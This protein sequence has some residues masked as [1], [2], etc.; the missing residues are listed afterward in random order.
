[1]KHLFLT[2]AAVVVV[3]A[4]CTSKELV[5]EHSDAM[6]AAIAAYVEEAAATNL[7]INSIM[8]LHHGKVVGEAYVN[9]WT[10]DSTHHMWSVSKS[11]TSMAIGLA[12]SEGK[13]SI[14][15]KI[16]DWF[17]EESAAVLDTISNPQWRQ[18]LMDCTIKDMLVMGCGQ[19]VEPI[20]GEITKFFPPEMA[21]DPSIMGE[22]LANMGSLAEKYGINYVQEFF[23]VP[24]KHEPGTHNLY[25]S[26]ASFVLS[27]IVEKATGERPDDYLTPRLWKKLGIEKP[28]WQQVNGHDG[29]GWGLFLRP[30]EMAKVGQMLLDGGKYAGKQVIPAD[31]LAEASSRWFKWGW[32]IWDPYQR[33][34]GHSNGYACQFWT[35]TEGFYAAGARGQFIIVLPKFDAV[36]VMT[37]EFD[38]DDQPEKDLAWKHIIP[39]L[40]QETSPKLEIDGTMG[41]LR[42]EFF[43]PQSAVRGEKV[44]M[45][46]VCHGFTG[47]RYESVLAG[48]CLG[49]QE[50]G[51]AAVRFDFNGH[52]DSD[53]RFEDMTFENEI[54]DLTAVYEYVKGLDFVDTSRIAVVGHSQG[55]VIVSMFAGRNNDGVKCEVLLAPGANL[56]DEARSGH[57]V[58]VEFDPE[59][60]P[61]SLDVW[62]HKV[63]RNYIEVAQNTDAYGEAGKFT[64]KAL[65]VHGDKDGTVPPEYGKKYQE[66][67]GD[68]EFTLIPDVGHIYEPTFQPAID[69]TVDFLKSNL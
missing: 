16:V 22:D 21:D 47:S 44:P 43:L 26:I 64:G 45:V 39:V 56:V 57:F 23:R 2:V 62:G 7:P 53:G 8:V 40:E 20:F 54:G 37:A 11:F 6:E 60:I 1:M 15:D 9:G 67:I 69:A 28:F 27:A 3:F 30:E 10:A 50:A 49:V 32:P 13:L 52:G 12:A 19:E 35:L 63:G 66:F 18:N 41:K 14:D 34:R 17:P 31:Y 5:R 48:T 55:G 25:N 4:G 65:V 51:M 68:C 46:I 38:D 58:G 61:E 29:G 24:F 36:I 33:G 59:N 42:G